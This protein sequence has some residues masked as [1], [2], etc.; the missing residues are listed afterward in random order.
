MA[1][2]PPNER[3]QVTRTTATHTDYPF[4]VNG[5]KFIS[6]ITIESPFHKKMSNLPSIILEVM[7]Q[8]IVE[9]EIGNPSQLTNEQ[10]DAG[11]ARLNEGASHAFI[12]LDTDTDQPWRN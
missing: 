1:T 12:L 10:L 5:V 8:E 6:R 9:Q 4:V 3:Q 7:N 2:P 11:L